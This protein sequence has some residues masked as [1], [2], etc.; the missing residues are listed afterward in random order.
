[1]GETHRCTGL[2]VP[3]TP[4]RKVS[5]L[6]H[7]AALG[8]FDD[9]RAALPQRDALSCPLERRCRCRGSA[10]E[11]MRGRL[12]LVCSALL[13]LLA[14]AQHPLRL[15]QP[16]RELDILLVG[17]NPPV[18][19]VGLGEEDLSQRRSRK[20][21]GS[22]KSDLCFVRAARR[23]KLGRGTDGRLGGGTLFLV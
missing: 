12:L 13:P 14:R 2:G 21:R 23:A 11:C 9:P 8:V 17:E 5:H 3:D 6:D 4:P 20:S 7:A 10:C 22:D 15:L 19:A 1:M 16:L 18:L